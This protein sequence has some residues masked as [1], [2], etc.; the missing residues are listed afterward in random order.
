MVDI[1]FHNMSNWFM[2]NPS[3]FYDSWLSLM[4]LNFHIC[5]GSSARATYMFVCLGQVFA[6]FLLSGMAGSAECLDAG[7][8]FLACDYGTISVHLGRA[9]FIKIHSHSTVLIL[10][11]IN[12]GQQVACL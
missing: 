6:T 10:L 3:S 8:D 11:L 9:H 1:Q 4:N 12:T 5:F 7:Q 2:R